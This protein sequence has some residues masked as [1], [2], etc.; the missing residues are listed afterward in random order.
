MS[1]KKILLLL[2]L[3]TLLVLPVLAAETQESGHQIAS[4]QKAALVTGA[5][6]GIGRELAIRLIEAGYT[7][8]GTGR[9]EESLRGLKAV[10]P[11]FRGI[12]ADFTRNSDIRHI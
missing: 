10:Y 8:F 3:S 12:K 6:R 1:K 5:T 11:E 4:D 7:V 2:I 9:D